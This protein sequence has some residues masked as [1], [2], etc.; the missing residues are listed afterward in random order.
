MATFDDSD[1]PFLD[2]V[3]IQIIVEALL[4]E[5][6]NKDEDAVRRFLDAPKSDAFSWSF[7]SVRDPGRQME[8]SEA[9][10]GTT[11]LQGTAPP[12]GTEVFCA[13]ED[14]TRHGPTITW[15][16]GPDPVRI[17][18]YRNGA[19]ASVRY[20]SGRVDVPPSMF[21]CPETAKLEASTRAG[22]QTK[23]CVRDGEPVGATVSWKGDCLLTKEAGQLFVSKTCP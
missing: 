9:C 14:G 18:Y 22:V 15:A 8:Q 13:R 17:A 6:R 20:P 5:G 23:R 10:P 19:V 7:P 1:T 12:K 2:L 16:D 4:A 21:L 11:S 3:S